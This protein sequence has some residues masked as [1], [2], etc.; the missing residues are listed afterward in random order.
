MPEYDDDEAIARALQ[1]QFNQEETTTQPP[2]QQRQQQRRSSSRRSRNATSNRTRSDAVPSAP[3]EQ[4]IRGQGISETDEEYARR[5]AREEERLYRFYQQRQQA[6]Q[7]NSGSN[8]RSSAPLPPPVPID[9]GTADVDFDVCRSDSDDTPATSREG[10]SVV[11]FEDEE[12]A[13]RVE[14]E[15]QDEEVARQFQENEEARA[16][17]AAAREVASQPRPRYSFNCFCGYLVFFTVLGAAVVAF[18]YFFYIQD[19]GKPRNWIWDPSEFADEDVSTNLT[20]FT[21]FS[22]R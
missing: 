22:S 1:E 18:F 5:I 2:Q 7:S 12:Y 3:P 15:L 8:Y 11:E 13:R 14:Q 4:V 9:T 19:N 20:S 16:S 21:D 17:R 10:S 6:Q